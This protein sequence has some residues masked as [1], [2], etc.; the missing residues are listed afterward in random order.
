MTNRP[1]ELDGPIGIVPSLKFNAT[2]LRQRER[3]PFLPDVSG[4][5]G[6]LRALAAHGPVPARVARGRNGRGDYLKLYVDGRYVLDLN[7]TKHRNGYSVTGI[8]PMGFTDHDQLVRGSLQLLTTGWIY[9]HQIRDLP[10]AG[11]SGWEDIQEEWR[12]LHREAAPGGADLLA[13]HER[14]LDRLEE[15]VTTGRRLEQEAAGSAAAVPYRRVDAAA[16]RRRTARAVY[17][18]QLVGDR[19]L[20]VGT[21]VHVR[22]H[23]DLQGRVVDARGTVITVRFER[24]VDWARIPAM[25]G[26]VESPAVTGFDKQLEALEILRERRAANPHLLDVLAD[27]TF[28]PFQPGAAAD[29]MP[30]TRLDDSQ[31][32][33]FRKALEAPDL[34][35]ILGPPGTGKTRTIVEVARAVAATGRRV[36]ITSYTNRAVDNA[37]KELPEDSLVLL[38]AGREEGV[39]AECE[40]LTMEARAETV[41]TEI[42]QRTEATARHYDTAEGDDW[43]R[44]L[45]ADLAALTAAEAT[46]RQAAAAW[47][48]EADR[49]TA[50][51]RARAEAL[52]ADEE[53]TGHALAEIRERGE[54]LVRAR[55]RADRR[56]GLTLVGFLFRGGARRAADRLA[57]ATAEHDRLTGVLHGARDARQRAEAELRHVRENAPELASLRRSA[58]QA[59]DERRKR[60]TATRDTAEALRSTIGGVPVPPS[61]AADLGALGIFRDHAAGALEL[62]RRRAALLA[63]WRAQLLQNTEQLYPELARYAD[64]IGA[65]CIGT[66][67]A[68]ALTGLDFDLAIVDEAGQISTPNMLVPLVR[69]RRA[70]LVGDH[71]QL[72]PFTDDRMRAWADRERPE[73]ADLVGRSGFELLFPRT[74]PANR[75]VLRYQR[76]MPR[77]VARF[78]SDQFYNGFLETD[79]ERPHRDTLFAS[80]LAF[81][82]TSGEPQRRRHDRPPRPDEPWAEHGWA[83]DLEARIITEIVSYYHRHDPDWAVILPFRAQV[84]LVTQHLTRRLGAPDAVAA[85]VGTVDSFQGGERRLI[86]FGFTRSNASGRVGFLN[87]LRRSN[88]AFSRPRN[89]LVLVG[90]TSTLRRADD[91]GFR[92]VAGSLLDHVRT[93]GDL[94]PWREIDRLLSGEAR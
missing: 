26:F 65:T 10:Y 29:V 47:Q 55:E 58:N 15:I 88:V 32:S 54:R 41:Q 13:S 45:D 87:D 89:L 11:R 5:I 31:L 67:T 23:S 46:A 92:A 49:F 72:G 85:R 8:W 33:A 70:L 53:R 68:G 59:E 18:F 76:R 83:N 4:I 17:D 81:V 43:L 44:Q 74:P 50:P 73:A 25:G 19:L 35:L 90:D 30:A 9:H 84:G 66:A 93:S 14:Y 39:T 27:G 78:I 24:P 48:A 6:D 40:H 82:D 62:M 37:L 79:V 16:A 51:L 80:P 63:D 12:S 21:R 34:A 22:E 57:E 52:A 36:L 69:A 1:V 42:L 75:E 94:R 3:Y 61:P 60:M 64:V 7:E 71:H 56:A 2:L 20:A 86:V 91:P 77:V 28:T 38:R